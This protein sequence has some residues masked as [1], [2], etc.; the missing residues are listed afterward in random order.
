MAADSAAV[1]QAFFDGM[2]AHDLDAVVAVSDEKIEF[3]DL[4]GNTTTHGREELRAYCA[5][6]LTGFPD[7]ELEVKSLFG[8]GEFAAVEAVAH[9]THTGPLGEIP[10][11]G[12]IIEVPFAIVA[13]V[14]GGLLA[15]CREYY[16]LGTLMTQLGVVPEPAAAR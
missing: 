15:D 1:V 7:L 9:G 13:R 16:D 5:G 2:N 6:Y 12:R 10:A 3:I 14:R 11:T 8:A 4:G